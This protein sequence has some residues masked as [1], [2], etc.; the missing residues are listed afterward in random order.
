MMVYAM[1]VTNKMPMSDYDAWA[2]E[3]RPEKLPNAHSND[4]R[5]HV[6][7][8]IYDFATNPPRV[9]PG[10]VHGVYEREHD[11]SGEYA[12]LSEHFFYLGDQPLALPEVLKEMVQRT[13]GHRSVS[14]AQ[15][16]GPFLKWLAKLDMPVN[17]LHGIPSAW[18]EASPA[19]TQLISLAPRPRRS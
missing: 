15:Y 19:P 11:L 6:G 2:R 5:L 1:R 3:H 4:P 13:Q 16:L 18:L 10:S 17:T 12:L 8:A 14:N 7:D 9:R